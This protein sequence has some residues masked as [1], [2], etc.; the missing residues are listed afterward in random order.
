MHGTPTYPDLVLNARSDVLSATLER[1]QDAR[2]FTAPA[3]PPPPIAYEL[4]RPH[5]VERLAARWDKSLTL[6]V[7]GP[8]FGKST[9]LAQAMRVHALEPFGIE[10]WAACRPGYEQAER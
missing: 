4:A 3:G 7:A 5:L 9:V 6:V 10:G 1:D 8:G 2:P